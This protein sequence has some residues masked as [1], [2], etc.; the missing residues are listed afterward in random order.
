[1][2][3]Q[4]LQVLLSADEAVL[5]GHMAQPAL[6]EGPWRPAAHGV[7]EHGKKPVVEC[8]P[9]AQRT[10]LVKTHDEPDDAYATASHWYQLPKL[11]QLESYMPEQSTLAWHAA[12][13]AVP[14]A[15]SVVEAL[16]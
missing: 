4:P 10:G 5:T 6:P 8:V 7:P 9:A 2:T 3:P 1:M 11:S 13:A 15:Y 12:S 16:L 14:D